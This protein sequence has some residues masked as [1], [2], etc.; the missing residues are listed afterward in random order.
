MKLAE[1]KLKKTVESI[2]FMGSYEDY[3][4][5]LNNANVGGDVVLGGTSGMVFAGG[6]RSWKGNFSIDGEVTSTSDN[7]TLSINVN[8]ANAREIIDR[9]FEMISDIEN[10]EYQ[11]VEEYTHERLEREAREAAAEAARLEAERLAAAEEERRRQEEEWLRQE[12]E[13]L[14]AAEEERRRQEEEWAK[15]E[16]EKAE[17]E[18]GSD[19][20][21][22][23]DLVPGEETKEPVEDPV[24]EP[25]KEEG[26]E[27]CGKIEDLVPGEEEKK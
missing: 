15:M 17:Q 14:A 11:I 25:K 13:R 2:E 12:E 8:F 10:S 7:R 26:D 4:I 19:C 16:Q 3:D 27:T 1:A 23:E 18:T 21:K 9:I 24:E 6:T 5:T 20:G 22:I